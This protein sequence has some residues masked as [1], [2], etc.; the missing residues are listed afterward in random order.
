MNPEDARDDAELATLLPVRSVATIRVKEHM[1]K[2]SSGNVEIA[3][4]HT[5]T[6]THTHEVLD[7][8]MR[9]DAREGSESSAAAPQP[10][11]DMSVFATITCVGVGVA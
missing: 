8:C 3:H 2:E 9:E 4:A 6:H 1:S 10:L 5:H 7:D 11:R